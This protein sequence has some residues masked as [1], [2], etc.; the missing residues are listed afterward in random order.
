MGRRFRVPSKERAVFTNRERLSGMAADRRDQP[1]YSIA[2]AARYV[3][4]APATLRSWVAGRPYKKLGGTAF[5]EPLIQTADPSKH[6]LSFHN[7]VEAHVLRALRVQHAVKVKEVREAARYAQKAFKIDRLLLSPELRAQAGQLFLDRYGELVN[8]SKSGQLA[9]RKLLEAYLERVDWKG[10][11][12]VRLYPFVSGELVIDRRIVIDP[13]I[14][15]GR[16]VISRRSVSTATI[17]ERIDAGE[18]VRDLAE[19]YDLRPEEIEEAVLYESA[20]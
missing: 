7:L 11:L 20:A 12:P 18:S 6:L 19:D 1:A 15:F 4:V 8:L 10:H 2:E 9:M 5:F 17:A 3:R 14:A 13:E 16:P